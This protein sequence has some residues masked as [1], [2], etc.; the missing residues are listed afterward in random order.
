MAAEESVEPELYH[1]STLS[2]AFAGDALYRA[3][4]K[5]ALA[6]A[7]PGAWLEKTPS[8]DTVLALSHARRHAVKWRRCSEL[9]N[10]QDR[11][12]REFLVVRQLSSWGNVGR[13]WA[14]RAG[15]E[16]DTLNAA[17]TNTLWMAFC[18]G[19][20]DGRHGGRELASRQVDARSLGQCP[21]AL[22]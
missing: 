9:V 20:G 4:A 7:A 14:L 18:A 13:S 6:W 1:H 2:D 8:W 3:L 22:W 12:G 10:T 21:H 11:I 19:R 16:K 15:L 17:R 5:P